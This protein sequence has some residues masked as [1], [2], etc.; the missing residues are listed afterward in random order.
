MLAE[1]I[2]WPSN[3]L[4]LV[5]IDTVSCNERLLNQVMDPTPESCGH[6]LE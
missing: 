3:R 6:C 2:G 1:R 4:F 5:V